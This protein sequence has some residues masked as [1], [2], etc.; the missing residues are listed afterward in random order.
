MKKKV[1]SIIFLLIVLIANLSFASYDTVKMEV[2]QE[3]ICEIKLGENSK[4]QKQL[5]SKDLNNKE[6]TLELKVTNEDEAAKPTGE[7]VLVLD[8]SNSTNLGSDTSSSR[9]KL[10]YDSTKKLVENLL[11]DNTKLKIGVVG[12]SA[13]NSNFEEQGTIEDAYQI[14]SLSNDASAI[15]TSI[16]NMPTDKG[17]QTNVEAGLELASKQL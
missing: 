9:K 10:I 7:L 15:N 3:P 1:L 6:V 12:F 4:F 11:K 8:N 2:V 17:A 14:A 16:D 5:I 13:K